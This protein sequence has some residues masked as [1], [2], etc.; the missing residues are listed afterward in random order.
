MVLTLASQ[1][2]VHKLMP[3]FD[4]PRQLTRFSWPSCESGGQESN[5]RSAIGPEHLPS[6]GKVPNQS[7]ER[8]E[9]IRLRT[10]ARLESEPEG[11]GTNLRPKTIALALAS[12]ATVELS[13]IRRAQSDVRV[14][15]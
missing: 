2:P 4:T 10:D 7:S 1:E 5:A 3:S 15:L 14:N 8:C 12:G 11:V 6:K 13:I 9:G